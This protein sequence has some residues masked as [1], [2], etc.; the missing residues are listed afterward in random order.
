MKIDIKTILPLLL[1]NAFLLSAN[2]IE[3]TPPY[4]WQQQF[5]TAPGVALQYISPQ[6]RQKFNANLVVTINTIPSEMKKDS[7]YKQLGKHITE[8]QIRL[9][10]LYKVI[11]N[12]KA[13]YNK[14]KG[15]LVVVSY[16]YGE[17]DIAAYQFV[18]IKDDTMYSVVYTCLLSDSQK[19][20]GEFEKSLK[21][22]SLKK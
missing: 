11:E 13:T 6:T 14:I 1:V 20:K 8:K 22:I 3:I 2:E 15:N 18:F 9:F 12:R 17:L 4:N 21:T 10:P 5:R 19:N 16:A 7:S